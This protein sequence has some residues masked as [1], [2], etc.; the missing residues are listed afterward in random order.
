L[1]AKIYWLSLP[2]G[3]LSAG[4]E[5]E[6]RDLL[7]TAFPKFADFFSRASYRVSVTTCAFAEEITNAAIASAI[8]LYDNMPLLLDELGRQ[9]ES[10]HCAAQQSRQ[11]PAQ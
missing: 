11:H 5:A 1:F 8:A 7:V 3:N 10:L 6:I 4:V 9:N 2:E